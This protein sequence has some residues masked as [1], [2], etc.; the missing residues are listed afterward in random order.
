MGMGP[1]GKLHFWTYRGQSIPIFEFIT[2]TE[3]HTTIMSPRISFQ[4]VRMTSA[5]KISNTMV[6]EEMPS[7]EESNKIKI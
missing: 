3:E 6:T 2:H 1:P 5:H 7:S 4:C